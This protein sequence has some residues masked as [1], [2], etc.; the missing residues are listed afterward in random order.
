MSFSHIP[1]LQ[2]QRDLYD[3]PRGGARF[4][5]YI[6]LMTEGTDEMLP[7]SVM[8]PVGKAHVA[9]T[10]DALLELGAEG[11]AAQA[12]EDAARRLEPHVT[13][14]HAFVVADDARGGWTDRYLTELI[15]RS[16]VHAEAVKRW[17]VTLLWTS[18]QVTRE[19]VREE[20]AAQLYRTYR[21][22]RSGAPQTLQ[23]WLAQEGAALAFAGVAP[24]LDA[25]DIAYSLEVITPYLSSTQTPVICAGLYGDR[26]ATSVGYPA[27]GL[28]ERAGF[29]VGLA[30]ALRQAGGLKNRLAPATHAT[31][32][33]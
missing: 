18:E 4:E 26:A 8:N 33:S 21:Q 29:A 19:R 24:W 14:R 22:A 15:H 12:V 9:R 17:T 20:V 31:A 3:L 7:L 25:D 28:S 16:D 10:L 2:I 32:L 23:A 11:I 27:L 1:L 13:W 6:E 30:E 5:R